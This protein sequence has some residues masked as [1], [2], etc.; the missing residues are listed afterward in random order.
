MKTLLEHNRDMFKES[1]EW[2]RR[3]RDE[4]DKYAD[5]LCDECGEVLF[6]SGPLGHSGG[7]FFMREVSCP[8]CGRQGIKTIRM[9]ELETLKN[10]DVALEDK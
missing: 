6:Y 3:N 7:P 2:F 8:N 4:E 10:W 5:L 9:W 1:D